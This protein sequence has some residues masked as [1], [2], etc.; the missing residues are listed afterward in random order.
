MEQIPTNTPIDLSKMEQSFVTEQVEF[1][2]SETTP[3]YNKIM[4]FCLVVK[5]IIH[6]ATVDT[7]GFRK[8]YNA[9]TATA[10]ISDD[11]GGDIAL[12]IIDREN[13][14]IHN[15][16]ATQISDDIKN[17]P[18]IKKI[19]E[20]SF[21]KIL[22]ESD[23]C[24]NKA[25][26]FSYFSCI[27]YRKYYI[28]KYSW[29]VFNKEIIDNILYRIG[30]RSII[31]IGSGKGFL[32]TL[33][34]LKGI[35]V[36]GSDPYMTQ[37]SYIEKIRSNATPLLIK[38]DSILARRK[39]LLLSWIEYGF[40]YGYIALKL[41]QGD[42]LLLVG[43]YRGSCANEAFFNL[44]EIEW[45]CIYSIEPRHWESISDVVGIY[46]RKIEFPVKKFGCIVWKNTDILF[47]NKIH[48]MS[49]ENLIIE[50]T[51]DNRT[52]KDVLFRNGMLFSEELCN[53]LLLDQCP[54][55]GDL[56]NKLYLNTELI[57]YIS[58]SKQIDEFV[59]ELLSTERGIITQ[60][61][62]LSILKTDKRFY[63]TQCLYTDYSFDTSI[64]KIEEFL[65]I[66]SSNGISV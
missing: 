62:I 11:G 14:E 31:E 1:Y 59:Y 46:K 26:D 44:L 13:V 28:E 34:R 64:D 8:N 16:K 9:E 57:K 30:D 50:I 41:F 5:N 12:S 4:K 38:Y 61:P 20:E 63:E 17:I 3:D 7:I 37:N 32:A 33:L 15:N 43:E 45:D 29:T 21:N 36:L 60:H 19:S 25:L 6:I 47:E 52:E 42:M 58:G 2:N 27:K 35:D 39:A 18:E 56:K 22:D 23:K 48:I 51:T 55:T 54:D 10:S 49:I 65:S 40:G 53:F 24:F 66:F